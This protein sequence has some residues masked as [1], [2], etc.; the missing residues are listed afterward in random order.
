MPEVYTRR[1][2]ALSYDPSAILFFPGGLPG[3]ESETRFVLLEQP[4]FAPIVFLQS[5]DS[6]E[7]CFLAAPV[8]ALV[9]GYSLSIAREDLERLD[10]DPDDRLEPGPELLCLA[11]LCTPEN[12][13]VTANL[14]APVV[15][16]LRT[17]RAVQAVRTDSRYSHQHAIAEEAAC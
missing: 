1:F 16:N 3:F 15:I 9:A 4:E 2:G 14:L 5:I 12:G 8:A 6:A 17:R 11:I 7:L 13:A 10:L